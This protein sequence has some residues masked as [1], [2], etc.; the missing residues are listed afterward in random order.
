MQ[1]ARFWIWTRFA[2]TISYDDNHCTTGTYL[3]ETDQS[4][5]RND[6][7]KGVL[8]IPNSWKITESSLSEFLV[9]PNNEW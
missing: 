8:H 9:T 1:L 7:N 3:K 5:P 4:G 2:V 6:G